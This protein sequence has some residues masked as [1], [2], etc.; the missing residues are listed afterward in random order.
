MEFNGELEILRGLE[1][2]YHSPI[3]GIIGPLVD[4]YPVDYVVGS[5]H[6]VDGWVID[7]PETLTLDPYRDCTPEEL[8]DKYL[9]R[10]E[11]AAQSGLFQ[12][13]AHIDFM[14]KCWHAIGGKPKNWDERIRKT[15]KVLKD[16]GVTVELN[17]RGWVL[18]EVDDSYPSRDTLKILYETGV[19]VTIG[20]D[21]HSL[22]RVGDGAH[23][24][25]NLLH[26]I[27]YRE[28]TVF[29]KRV[30]T[31]IPIEPELLTKSEHHE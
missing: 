19:P 20:S 12:M 8:A 31:T 17:T 27:G 10:L 4:R 24:A 2:D 15:A 22:D 13:M 9:R 11:E 28:L 18:P 5:V 6:F 21:A 14:K 23:H 16:T 1:V 25:I 7:D 3:V 26:E 30:P 29:R